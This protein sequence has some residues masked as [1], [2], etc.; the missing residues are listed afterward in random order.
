MPH[1]STGVERKFVARFCR[2]GDEHQRHG[3]INR[4]VPPSH[5]PLVAGIF[6]CNQQAG[7]TPWPW[8]PPT[9]SLNPS[10][11]L[12]K[13]HLTIAWFPRW[14]DGFTIGYPLQVA[15]YPNQAGPKNGGLHNTITQP[16]RQS[17]RP[18]AIHWGK[19]GMWPGVFHKGFKKGSFWV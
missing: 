7:G 1:L 14:R 2:L 15:S 11:D 12:T 9:G 3:L 5:N 8:N 18:L 17:R 16:L 6:D 13:K 4:E 10:T 19:T